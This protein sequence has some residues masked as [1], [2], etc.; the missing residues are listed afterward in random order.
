MSSWSTVSVTRQGRND[1]LFALTDNP[2]V[3]YPSKAM[4]LQRNSV[5]DTRVVLGFERGIE[6]VAVEEL[7]DWNGT[8]TSIQ[9]YA[10]RHATRRIAHREDSTR[11]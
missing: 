7:D 5:G 4:L 10:T 1:V 6:I 11:R 8:V 2:A 9:E 3:Y